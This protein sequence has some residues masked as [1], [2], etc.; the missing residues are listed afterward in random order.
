MQIQRENLIK[1]G[2]HVMRQIDKRGFLEFE[3]YGEAGTGLGP[4]LEFYDNISEEFR[5]WTVAVPPSGDQKEA[6]SVRMWQLTKDNCLYPAPMCSKKD[7]SVI[8]EVYE[9]FR[10]CG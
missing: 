5:N 9:T 8:K 4:T 6:R 3:F 7:Q 1:S 2:H 10:L